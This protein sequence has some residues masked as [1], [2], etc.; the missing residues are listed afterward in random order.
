MALRQKALGRQ[1]RTPALFGRQ[2]HPGRAVHLGVGG[3]IL[4][5]YDSLIA[6]T[7]GS[8]YLSQLGNAAFITQF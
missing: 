6:P 3:I 4:F 5:S 7:R 2:T 8:G 1:H